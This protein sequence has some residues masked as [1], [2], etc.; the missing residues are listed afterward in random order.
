ML[1]FPSTLKNGGPNGTSWR[2][3]GLNATQQKS[4]SDPLFLAIE[5]ELHDARRVHANGQEDDLRLALNMVISR[6]TQLVSTP[7]VDDERNTDEQYCSH[8]SS[9]KPTRLRQTLK[10]S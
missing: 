4:S 6:V 3:D 7:D 10:S 9:A 5:E 8:R 1:H 2:S